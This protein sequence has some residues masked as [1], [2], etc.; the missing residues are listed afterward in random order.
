MMR[1]LYR[2]LAISGFLVLGAHPGAAQ[3]PATVPG[4][5]GSRTCAACHASEARAW[6]GSHHAWAWTQ[7]GEATVLGDFDDVVFERN[8]VTTRFFR[9]DGA[10]L[11]E[12]EGADGAMRAF[13]VTGVAGVAPLQQYLLATGAG[14]LQ[15]FDI[16]WD[17]EGER[18]YHLYPDQDLPPGDGLHWTGPYK[19]WNARCA[20]CHATGFL[21]N[22]DAGARGYDSRQAETGVGC[23]ACH[24]PGSAHLAWAKA[25]QGYDPA[26]W[27]GSTAKGFTIGFGAGSPETEIEQ[28]AGCHSRREPFGDGNPL[29]GTAFH[30]AYRLA[31][32]RADLYHPDGTIKDEVYVY[33]SFLQSRMS[34]NGVR[35]SDCHDPHTAG[36][37]AAGNAVCT[38]CHSPAGNKR[39]PTLRL[40][41]YD[42][43]SHHFHPEDSAGAQCVG[44]HMIERTYMG[45]DGRRDHSFRIPRPDLFLATGAPNACTDCHA[46]R[47]AAWAATQIAQR[48]PDSDR[49]GA[50][51][52]RTF[53]AARHD[54]AA[55]A[56]NLL[57]IAE[58][59]G[60]PGLIRASALDLLRPV[61][62][63][64]IAARAAP[65]IGDDDPLVRAAAIALQRG[66]PPMDRVQRLVPAFEDPA[67]SVRIAAARAFLDAPVARL[68]AR[69]SEAAR[70]AAGEW[71]A[72]LL[73]K[74]DF[75]ETQMAIG[76][77]ALVLRN[78]R[79]AEKA[80]RE[81]VRLDPQ[82]VEAWAMIARILAATGDRDGARVALDD[83]LAANPSSE[84][85]QSL[86][87]EAE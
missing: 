1:L 27:P 18:W 67:R 86:R 33:G 50:H 77:A 25:P 63:A 28:C 74:T 21:K 79:A 72:S 34:A 57:G 12:T 40:A 84:V 45:I 9:R 82:R 8:G 6:T 65:L 56:E 37:K 73:A 23:E 53:A 76:G 41:D 26:A 70:N 61:A 31:L 80:F 13:E 22:Y 47:N 39:F 66:A 10:Y 49:R 3:A 60:L 11:V 38:Q 46:E 59:D 19:N 75:P 5:V 51:F 20:E 52:S 35:C 16:V 24:G 87:G 15:A 54:P 48:F 83:A 14:R 58:R 4:Y 32:L 81:T 55:S 36:L 43:P 85:L 42:D 29:P 71:R 62:D 30:D 78:P 44:C 69:I 2:L 7:P 64:A 17:V 68:P